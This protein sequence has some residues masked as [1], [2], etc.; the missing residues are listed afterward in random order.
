M[1]RL[2]YRRR[3]L[4]IHPTFQIRSAIGVMFFIVVYSAIL[5]FLIFYPMKVELDRVSD[6]RMRLYLA[7]QMLTLH[8]RLW[9]GV[10]AVA[11]LVGGQVIVVSHRIAGPLY[12]IRVALE[13]MLAGDYS[14]RVKLREN[15]RFQELEPLVNA[16][17][18]KL[19]ARNSRIDRLVAAACQDHA[20]LHEIRTLAAE[21]ASAPRSTQSGS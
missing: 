3:K 9:P 8:S 1:S 5:G 16:L 20:S 15:D 19:E 2:G 17:A 11:L 10:L 4:I 6:S 13:S 12:R 21:L 14:M 18:A 7:D